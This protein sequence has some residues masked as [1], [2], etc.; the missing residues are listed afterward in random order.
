[1][2]YQATGTAAAELLRVAGRGCPT[3]REQLLDKGG[4]PVPLRSTTYGVAGRYRLL[5]DGQIVTPSYTTG[6]F[7]RQPRTFIGRTAGGSVALVTIDGRSPRSVGATL[8]EEARVAASLGL[9]DAVNLDGGG[10]S[11]MAVRGRLVSTPAGG[12]ERAVGDAVVFMP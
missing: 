8:L 6:F 7:A 3:Y 5:R 9:V 4:S 12:R 10:S 11:A 2:S 1:M